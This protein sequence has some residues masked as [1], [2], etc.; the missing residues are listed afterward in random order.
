MAVPG[1]DDHVLAGAQ[2]FP[3]AYGILDQAAGGKVEGFRQERQGDA[4]C[5]FFLR[6]E[7]DL[8]AI[9]LDLLHR[10]A[11][12]RQPQGLVQDVGGFCPGDQAVGFEAAHHVGGQQGQPLQ[13][14]D[15]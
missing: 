9:P 4:L 2:F 10:A 15:P 5:C 6:F 11:D 14:L 13:E 7:Y 8:A 12:L 3:F 1:Q